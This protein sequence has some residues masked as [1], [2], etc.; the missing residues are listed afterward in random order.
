MNDIQYFTTFIA[1]IT[2]FLVNNQEI[3]YTDEEIQTHSNN[4]K[5]TQLQLIPYAIKLKGTIAKSIYLN[6]E[7]DIANYWAK[8]GFSEEQVIF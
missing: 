6:D 4:L 7:E 8:Q 2:N 1:Q 3:H 5:L